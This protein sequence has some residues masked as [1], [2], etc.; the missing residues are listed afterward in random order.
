ML[1]VWT[2]LPQHPLQQQE[3]QGDRHFIPRIPYLQKLTEFEADTGVAFNHIRL[4][5]RAFTDH[6]VGMTNLTLG[7]NQ[8]LEFLGDTVLQLIV[9]EHLYLH[10]PSHHEGHLSLLRTTLVNN[11]TQAIVCDELGMAR[12]SLSA[13]HRKKVIVG[14]E[15]DEKPPLKMKDKADLLEAYLGAL[16][17]DQVRVND[18]CIDY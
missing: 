1:K 8:R 2:E 18:L 15:S 10:F 14:D 7:S 16:Y 3:P 12:F 17:V 9:T 6:S 5:A 13:P 4:L 11:K